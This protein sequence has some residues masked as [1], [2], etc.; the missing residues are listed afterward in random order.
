[1]EHE[2]FCTWPEKWRLFFLKTQLISLHMSSLR[3]CLW[4][5]SVQVLDSILGGGG[6]AVHFPIVS[7][8]YLLSRLSETIFLNSPFSARDIYTTI[9]K[10][11]NLNSTIAHCVNFFSW[12]LVNP[13]PCSSTAPLISYS[14]GASSKG[15]RATLDGA[16]IQ[17]EHRDSYGGAWGSREMGGSNVQYIDD[18]RR[19]T[20]FGETDVVIM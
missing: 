7:S 19:S 8:I 2:I 3:I 20:G 17:M 15:S 5:L 6:G 14:L 9:L 16:P 13:I 4:K 1:M 11:W 12:D 10:K 18:E